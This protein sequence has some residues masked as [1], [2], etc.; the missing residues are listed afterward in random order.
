M[1]LNL[2]ITSLSFLLFL[3]ISSVWASPLTQ[4][5]KNFKLIVDG[6]W[7]GKNPLFL[8]LHAFDLNRNYFMIMSFML[9]RTWIASHLSSHKSKHNAFPSWVFANVAGTCFS[10]VE[11][12]CHKIA[13]GNPGWK[14]STVRS[15]LKDLAPP[16]HLLLGWGLPQTLDVL[17]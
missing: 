17:W 5:N 1:R 16:H 6:C 15:V 14:I 9:V 12:M 4:L 11:I 2:T 8:S 7:I 3:I 10:N 13:T